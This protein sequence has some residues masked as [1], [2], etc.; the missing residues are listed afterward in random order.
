M[1]PDSK[2]KD[3]AKISTAFFGST[4]YYQPIELLGGHCVIEFCLG[5]NAVVENSDWRSPQ[6]N[7][8]SYFDKLMA[9]STVK[10][11]M[12]NE[13]KKYNLLVAEKTWFLGDL[14][15]RNVV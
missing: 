14:S 5:N 4:N 9:K 2:E 1:V 15:M 13:L 8:D 7:K 12:F 11:K 10:T 3:F 6:R